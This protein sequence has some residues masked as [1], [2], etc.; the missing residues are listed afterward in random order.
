MSEIL[1]I[2]V[3]NGVPVSHPAFADNIMQALGRVPSDWEP[4]DRPFDRNIV[5]ELGLYQ[6]HTHKYV[7]E[8]GR[9]KDVWGIRHMTPEEKAEAIR[10][11]KESKQYPSWIFDEPTCSWLPPVPRPTN[12]VWEWDES[13]LS[14]KDVTP[15]EMKLSAVSFL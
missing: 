2:K 12:G 5:P 4:F 15:P 3:E 7:K 13:S 14:W 8:N 11:F 10:V 6:T 1:Y 9:W